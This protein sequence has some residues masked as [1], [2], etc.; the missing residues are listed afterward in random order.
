MFMIRGGNVI[1]SEHGIG[2]GVFLCGWSLA[3]GTK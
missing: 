3:L 2:T 1:D